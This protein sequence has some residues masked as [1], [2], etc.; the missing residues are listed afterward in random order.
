MTNREKYFDCP[1]VIWSFEHGQWWGPGHCGYTDYLSEAGRYTA[2]E[3]G[4]IVTN[5]VMGEEVTI[6]QRT[7]EI[8]GAPTVK[9]LWNA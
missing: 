4:E 5:S 1:Y 9:G 8:N 7:A 3:A 6:H 2:R